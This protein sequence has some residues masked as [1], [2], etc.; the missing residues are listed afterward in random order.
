[1]WQCGLTIQFAFLPN[2]G[3]SGR[4]PVAAIRVNISLAGQ[5][6]QSLAKDL[7]KNIDWTKSGDITCRSSYQAG[8]FCLQGG[9]MN[10]RYGHVMQGFNRVRRWQI[11]LLPPDHNECL[12]F[13]HVEE[14]LQIPLKRTAAESYIPTS[15]I[16]SHNAIMPFSILPSPR[17]SR[18]PRELVCLR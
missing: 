5:V 1:M 18:I 3:V 4:Q 12:L 16:E 17:E 2:K 11:K 13:I 9:L 6:E 7:S 14:F 15:S 10:C 8:V